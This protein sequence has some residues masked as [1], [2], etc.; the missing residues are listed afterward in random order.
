MYSFF[1]SSI[2][3]SLLHPLYHPLSSFIKYFN[4]QFMQQFNY[5]HL[6]ITFNNICLTNARR[7][8]FHVQDQGLQEL[9]NEDD[10][11]VPCARLFSIDC[12]AA[13]LFPNV[14]EWF[15]VANY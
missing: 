12:R 4:L 15:F 3:Y 6:P 9:H 7:R 1:H 11:S 10:L 13:Y 5:N 2:V 14:I 8:E